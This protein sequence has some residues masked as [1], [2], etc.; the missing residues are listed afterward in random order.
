MNCICNV[1][2]CL[3]VCEKVISNALALLTPERANLLLLSPENEGR[4]PLK[5]KWFGTQYSV[6]G[7]SHLAVL[8]KYDVHLCKCYILARNANVF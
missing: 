3:C 4:C 6:E 8:P 1:R 7:W 5:E 2:V